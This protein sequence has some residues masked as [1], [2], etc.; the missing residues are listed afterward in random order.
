M[1]LKLILDVFITLFF[2]IP[3]QSWGG[4]FQCWN[5]DHSVIT[6]ILETGPM[7][8][9]ATPTSVKV[10]GLGEEIALDRCEQRLQSIN[11]QKMIGIV[12]ESGSTE[13]RGLVGGIFLPELDGFIETSDHKNS[14]F[15]CAQL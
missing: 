3:I 9:G 13:G 7:T 15:Q 2:L 14:D 4:S 1:K 12:C 11:E 6:E 10:K 5:E 8:D